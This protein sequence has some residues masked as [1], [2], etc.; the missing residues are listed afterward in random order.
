M[1]VFLANFEFDGPYISTNHLSN[2]SGVYVVLDGNNYN[3]VLYVGS[4]ETIKYRIENHNRK[5]DWSRHA[6]SLA[7]AAFYCSES[8]ARALEG[9]LHRELR[10]LIGAG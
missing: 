9:R 1:S 7:F 4:S 8:D 3:R 10:P 2:K 5:S 6:T